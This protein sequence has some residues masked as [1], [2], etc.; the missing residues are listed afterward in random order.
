MPHEPL[1]VFPLSLLVAEG[2]VGLAEVVACPFWLE[3]SEV[4]RRFADGVPRPI[5]A[6]LPIFSVYVAPAEEE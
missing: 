4:E 3:G 1:P 6:L 5:T 2:R